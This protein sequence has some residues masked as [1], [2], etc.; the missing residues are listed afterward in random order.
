MNHDI[1][2]PQVILVRYCTDTWHPRRYQVS[3][4]SELETCCEGTCGS[5]IRRSVS[6]TILF[7]K[8]AIV[9][10]DSYL[11]PTHCLIF[12]FK[13]TADLAELVYRA[14]QVQ[15]LG[16]LPNSLN[17]RRKPSHS[18]RAMYFLLGKTCVG[19]DSAQCVESALIR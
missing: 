11:N 2:V 1:E 10:I 9:Y 6:F 5:A 19:E 15:E 13:A 14:L 4:G 3:G 8:A 18:V 12:Q 17:Q 16:S 7:G